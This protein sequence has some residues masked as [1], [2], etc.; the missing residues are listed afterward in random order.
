MQVLLTGGTGFL[1][2]NLLRMLLESGY[3]V[4][5]TTRHSSDPRPFDGLT[6]ETLPI[7]LNDPNAVSRSVKEVDL[8]IHSAAMIHLG[9]TRQEE[10]HRFNV[11]GTRLLAQAARRN[12]IRN[13]SN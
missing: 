8:L 10:S 7:D 6:I 5:A 12:K 13:E 2:N 3:G 4:T 11:E 1:G 9:W